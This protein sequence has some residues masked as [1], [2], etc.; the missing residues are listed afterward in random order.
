MPM[1]FRVVSM[2]VKDRVLAM[3][4]IRA[5]VKS[6]F[7]AIS[8]LIRPVLWVFVF[9]EAL[10]AAFS[11]G[12]SSQASLDGAPDYFSFLAVGMLSAMPMLLASRGG[13]SL[14]ADR[15]SG[16]LDRLLVAPVS[17]ATIALTKVLGTVLF[18]LSQSVILLFIALPFGLHVANLSVAS[19]VASMAGVFLVAWGY[20]ALFMVMTFKVKRFTDMQLVFS[21]SFPIM[22]FSK[23]FYPSSRLP[24]WI[25]AF[26]TYNPVSYSADISRSLMFGSDG[27][28]ASSAVAVAFVVLVAFALLSSALLLVLAKE[29]L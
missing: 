1:N 26:A 3:R 11:L 12:S 29:W 2:L 22:L 16:Y 10:N 14:F 7:L 9:G 23:V 28:L 18:G 4:E 21:L 6:P 24:G 5:W 17:R 13:A 25:S 19:V 20:T 15:T 8:F 27:A